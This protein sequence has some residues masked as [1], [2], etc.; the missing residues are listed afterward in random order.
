MSKFEREIRKRQGFSKMTSVFHLYFSVFYKKLITVKKSIFFIIFEWS[1]FFPEKPALYCRIVWCPLSSCRISKK[2]LERL[3][4]TFCDRQTD[5]F[6]TLCSTAVSLKAHVSTL[7][8]IYARL[9]NRIIVHLLVNTAQLCN[10]LLS[11]CHSDHFFIQVILLL[12]SYHL[13]AS[14]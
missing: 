3:S 14:Y 10:L 8:K 4:R 5:Y 12:P 9:L 1:R 7:V 11:S 2:S 6:L 13:M